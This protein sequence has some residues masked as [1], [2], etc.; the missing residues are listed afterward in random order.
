MHG[1]APSVVDAQRLSFLGR[2]WNGASGVPLSGR[3]QRRDSLAL[4]LASSS[5]TRRSS[6]S[7]SSSSSMADTV[8]AASRTRTPPVPKIPSNHRLT[9]EIYA[10]ILK[11]QSDIDGPRSAKA[12]RIWDAVARCLEEISSSIDPADDGAETSSSSSEPAATRCPSRRSVRRSRHPSSSRHGS[13]TDAATETEAESRV[14]YP[15]PFRQR[16]PGRFNVRHY[17]QCAKAQFH[18]ALDLK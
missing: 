13:V 7:S 15:C 4:R 5:S 11:D 14:L 2:A 17:E 9:T 12:L 8:E 6:S 1:R 10:A 16:N 3:Q 18:W